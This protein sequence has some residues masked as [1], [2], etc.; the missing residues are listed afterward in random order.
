MTTPARDAVAALIEKTNKLHAARDEA[1][2]PLADINA[3]IEAA[4]TEL[5]AA[6]IAHDAAL[7]QEGELFVSGQDATAAT[8]DVN[9]KAAD[10]DRLRRLMSALVAQRTE[11][12][13]LVRDRET[14]LTIAESGFDALIANVLAEVSDEVAAE[15]KDIGTKFSAA[16]AKAKSLVAYVVERHWFP[17][18][19][20]LAQRFNTIAIPTW[21][22]SPKPDW[23]AFAAALESDANTEAA[24]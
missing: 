23:R 10:L 24:R 13:N 20:K 8:A 21:Q 15:L 1:L 9:S 2:A 17:L 18:G 3:K 11:Q 16:Q 6:E 12:E 14:S 5:S 7:R 22:A 19:E 4:K